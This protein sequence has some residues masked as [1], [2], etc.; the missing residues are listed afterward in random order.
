MKYV[1][2]GA[3][4]L[5][6]SRVALGTMTFGP[7]TPEKD[8]HAILDRAIDMGINLIDTSCDYG[9]AWGGAEQTI[10]SWL[11][12]NPAKRDRIVLATKV[13]QGKPDAVSPNDGP[14]LSRYK[15]R[16]QVDEALQRLHTDHIDLYQMHHVDRTI[17]IEELW[18]T[19][20]DL[21][22]QGKISYAGTSNYA[23]WTLVKHQ[24][25]A[26]ARGGLGFVSEQTM[27][28][29]WCRYAE[30]EMLPAAQ[31]MG[32]GVLGYMPL[33]GGLL[34]GSEAVAGS[35]TAEVG[36]EYA[37]DGDRLDTATAV[38]RDMAAERDIA[39][40]TLAT[41]WTLSRPGV[42]AAVV[43]ARTVA[44]LDGID[45]AATLPLSQDELARLDYA[46]PLGEGKSLRTT[47][48]PEAYAW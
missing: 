20:D 8:A 1:H 18:G 43:G 4:N 11:A 16:R 31:D 2:L 42:A 23:A 28:N 25:A 39:P 15:L 21:T 48:T 36:K 40:A 45:S 7:R 34:T 24:M 30:L 32:V 9:T 6:V 13:Y 14:G 41:A 44:H 37:I 35:R 46:F 5:Y 38:L 22:S 10:G 26:R 27:L 33:A 29:L 3:S 19:L 47:S 17:Q 12:K